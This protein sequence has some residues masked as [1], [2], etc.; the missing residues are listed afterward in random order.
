[1]QR[2]AILSLLIFSALGAFAARAGDAEEIEAINKAAAALDAAFEKDDISAIKQLMTPDHIAVTPYYDGPQSVAD[3]T[4]SLPDLHYGQTIVGDVSVTLLGT[5]TAWRSFNAKLSGSFRGR[6]L[7]PHA[8]V[9][10]IWIKQDGAWIEKLHQVTPLRHGH[11]KRGACRR[12]VGT[13]LTKNVAKGV[14]V[15]SVISRSIIS[16]DR[17]GLALFTDSG[18]G[19]E[20]GF[21]PFT[22][23]RGTW[24]CLRGEDGA[25]KARAT[26]LDF[27][28]PTAEH[29]AAGIGR[30]DFEFAADPGTHALSGT[31]RLYLVPLGSDPLD[32]AALKDGRE[33]DITTERIEVP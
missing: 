16:L 17:S 18:E 28:L 5:E 15:E 19:G 25:V 10:G 2:V 30:L 1:M 4:A 21:A 6:R 13:Y 7:P 29:P 23:G 31:A 9:S 22:D 32:E 24:R 12:L 11:G 27:T 33:F 14:G 26:T 20:A 3:H 8:F